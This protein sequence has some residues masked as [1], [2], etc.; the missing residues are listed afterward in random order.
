MQ[1]SS[2]ALKV[3]AVIPAAGHSRRMG[4][5]KL[6]LP[7]GGQTVL[8]RLLT[9]LELPEII[10]RAVVLRADDTALREEAQRWGAQVVCPAVDPPDMRASVEAGLAWIQATYQPAD[11][12]A[13]LLMPADHPLL[14]RSLLAQL[15]QHF[16]RLRPLGLVPTYAGRRGHPLLARW[17]TVQELRTL[18]AE[19]G[20]NVWLRQRLDQIVEYPVE[21]QAILCDLDTPDDYAR[22]LRL[23]GAT[24]LEPGEQDG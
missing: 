15:V 14:E 2:P 18:P 19:V 17:E 3:Y 4:Q 16:A 13:W 9:A 24:P 6:L 5:P 7:L 11:D 22:L 10:C 23:Y 8:A 21:S 12:A 20:L 1:T